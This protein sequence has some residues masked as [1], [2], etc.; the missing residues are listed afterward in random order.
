MKLPALTVWQ[1]WA[2]LIAARAKP[3]EFR[4][5]AAP[6]AY[7]NKPL[8]IHAAARKVDMGEIRALRLKLRGDNE[9]GLIADIALPL[10]ERW[11]QDPASLPLSSIVCVVK[12]GTPIRAYDIPEFAHQFVNDSDRRDHA[13]WG[14]PMLDVRRLEPP[15]P[16]RGAQ[17]FWPCELPAESGR[18][19]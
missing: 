17:G 3:Y 7:R 18:A 2:T 14:W 12:L 10:L 1:P 9:T 6:A 8:A 4:G 13:Q 11:S 15:V 5:W 16:Y 19:A